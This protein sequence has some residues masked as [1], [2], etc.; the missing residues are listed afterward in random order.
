MLCDVINSAIAIIRQ[1]IL[2]RRCARPPGRLD[3]YR[4]DFVFVLNSGSM[5]IGVESEADTHPDMQNSSGPS[6]L[7]TEVR[8]DA[9]QSDLHGRAGCAGLW[10]PW[11]TRRLAPL[12]SE[13]VFYR[14]QAVLEGRAPALTAHLRNRPD[15]PLR[16]FVRCQSCGRGLTASWSRSKNQDKRY[17]YYHCRSGPCRLT[18]ISKTRLEGLFAEALEE[19]QPTPGYMRLVTE[20]VLGA[21]GQHKARIKE[22]AQQ[23]VRTVGVVQ[24][25][26]D[27]L[28]DAFLFQERID[29]ETYERQ[30]DRL[31]QEMTLAKMAKHSSELDELDV[32]GILAFAERVL[33][34]A[35][36]VWIQASLA[37]RQQ[38]QKLFFPEGIFFDGKSIVRTPPRPSAFNWLEAFRPREKGVVDQTGFEPVT[39]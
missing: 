28:D 24:A 19:L 12:V 32:E 15:F 22:D 11:P 10:H 20:T 16:G 31:R 33:P 38:L 29:S 14:V 21:W 27:K 6:S 7:V 23:A 30:R 13:K 39:S 17:A 18:N 3:A 2:L 9:A 36:D 26:L 25:K 34:R 8:R 35:S 4:R 5:R 1:A 37:Q